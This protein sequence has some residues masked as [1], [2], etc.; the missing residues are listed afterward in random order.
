LG[1]G[2]LAQSGV[3]GYSI[4]RM[5]RS[6]ILLILALFT[7]QPTIAKAA[8]IK[9]RGDTVYVSGTIDIEDLSLAQF[10]FLFGPAVRNVSLD[11]RGGNLAVALYAARIIAYR[12]LD[13]RVDRNSSCSS[14]CVLLLLAGR[15]RFVDPKA[16][17]GVH[18]AAPDRR[19][20]FTQRVNKLLRKGVKDDSLS[21]SPEAIAAEVKAV[22]PDIDQ[23]YLSSLFRKANG[24][25]GEIYWVKKSELLKLGI[26][27]E[28]QKPI[29]PDEPAADAKVMRS[30]AVQ[31]WGLLAD[32]KGQFVVTCNPYNGALGRPLSELEQNV[33]ALC[34]KGFSKLQ[35]CQDV[36]S[37]IKTLDL[38]IWV[39]GLNEGFSTGAYCKSAEVLN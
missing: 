4:Y 10:L 22:S 14:A 32:Q 24:E 36:S 28:S 23:A 34:G 17:I 18:T 8:T 9:F 35:M 12:G 31:Q 21:T 20:N 27:V 11:S 16:P 39:N 5:A 37:L 26:A 30:L 6:F 33:Q 19:S 13:T 3:C 25:K 2:F 29:A 7:Q 15:H 38:P 1:L